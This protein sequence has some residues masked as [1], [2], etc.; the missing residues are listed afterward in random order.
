MGRLVEIAYE[1]NIIMIVIYTSTRNGFISILFG[2]ARRREDAAMA[3]RDSASASASIA[4]STLFRQD[5]PGVMRRG[6]D[7]LLVKSTPQDGMDLVVWKGCF[8]QPVE[9]HIR[10]D[11]QWIS[12]SCTLSGASQSR[13][14]ATSANPPHVLGE[15]A[16]GIRFHPG[17]RGTFTQAS[18]RFES[19][20]VMMRP[21]VFAAWTGEPQAALRRG[22]QAGCYLA[23]CASNAE[24][25]ATAQALSR[26]L[27]AMHACRSDGARQAPPLWLLGQSLVMVSLILEAHSESAY[28]PHEISWSDQQRLR[29]A[30][31]RLLSDLSHAPT[32]VEL[33]REANLS[34]LKLKRGFRQVFSNSVYGLFQHERMQHARCR[35][36]AGTPVLTVAAELGYT[37]AS[38]FSAAFKKQF[39]VN[40]SAIK[41]R[42]RV[43]SSGVPK[44][45]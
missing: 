17:Q 36:D 5:A 11:V 37:N 41:R 15:K 16:A 10:D 40:P 26:A 7:A 23:Q 12:F 19:L 44:A 43:V 9:M 2:I 18:G 14:A 32:V 33:A 6:G 4:A 22:M 31:D 21:D 27:C 25:L 24:L 1:T 13:F 3:L 42:C 29:R 8:D 39:G 35:L 28:R 38:H 30:R 45:V 34:V 20:S